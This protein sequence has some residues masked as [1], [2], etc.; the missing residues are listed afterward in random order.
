MAPV[1]TGSSATGSQTNNA[2]NNPFASLRPTGLNTAGGSQASSA[3]NLQPAAVTTQQPS[4]GQTLNQQVAQSYLP[5]SD[6]QLNNAGA[7]SGGQIQNAQA[8]PAQAQQIQAQQTEFQEPWQRP[9]GFDLSDAD[10]QMLLLTEFFRSFGNVS[11]PTNSYTEVPTQT[12][13]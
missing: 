8:Q 13:E 6:A 10:V 4:A 2:G 3:Q 12:P 11:V 1:S 5:A 9:E 7:Q